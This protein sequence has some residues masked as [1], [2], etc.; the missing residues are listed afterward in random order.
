MALRMDIERQNLRGL[1]RAWKSIRRERQIDHVPISRQ[2]IEEFSR[3][4]Y[5]MESASSPSMLALSALRQR[6]RVTVV[7]ALA[8]AIANFAIVG[9]HLK[10]VGFAGSCQWSTR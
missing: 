5:P 1:E 8:R 6:T 3:V 4:E 2:L 9:R 10:T 7:T